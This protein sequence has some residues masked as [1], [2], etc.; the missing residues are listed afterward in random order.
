MSALSHNYKVFNDKP[1]LVYVL[2]AYPR[3]NCKIFLRFF[4]STVNLVTPI[5]HDD[6]HLTA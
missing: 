3:V 2:N 1:H 6:K 5:D 4:V